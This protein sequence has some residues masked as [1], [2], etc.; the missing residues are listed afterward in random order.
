[1]GGVGMTDKQ[2]D[3]YKKQVMRRLEYVLE[4]KSQEKKDKELQRI[5]NDIQDELNRP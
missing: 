3:S 1:M 4:E 5:I 2:F